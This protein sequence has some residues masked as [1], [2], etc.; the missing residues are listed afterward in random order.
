MHIELFHLVGDYTLLQ[1]E[2]Y[3][4]T[5]W[6]WNG[7]MEHQTNSFVNSPT[8]NLAAHELAHQ[9]FGDLVT[10]GSWQDIW[11]NEGFATYLTLLSLTK[12]FPYSL[13][14]LSRHLIR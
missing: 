13:P 1:L 5:Q 14:T 11:L 9:W 12:L 2:K 10:C 8:P 7:G 3:G 6:G 4:H